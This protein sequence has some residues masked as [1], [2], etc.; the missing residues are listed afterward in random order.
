LI[1]VD[2]YCHLGECRVYDQNVFESEIVS[3]LNQNQVSA[4]IVA[5]FPGAPNPAS[6]HDRIADLGTRHPGRVFGLASVN[7]HI[8][9]DRY[10]AEVER[11]VKELGFVGVVLETLGHA[12]NPIGNDA[13]T[14]FEV[15]RQLHIPVVV[16]TG[17]SPYGLP[18]LV[19]PRAR[20]YSDVKIVL[21]NAGA[22]NYTQ[23]AQIVARE[24]SNVYLSTAWCR[25]D[26]IKTIVTDLGANR[27]MFAS[28]YPA[29]QTTELSKYRALTLFQFQQ[30]QAFSQTAM[31]VFGLQGVPDVPEVV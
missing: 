6:V 31:D 25:G 12:V 2:T 17:G 15:A 30:L 18:A 13:Q 3:T 20:S 19:L 28:D 5:P 1:I 4:V 8:N 14:V 10:R 11:C 23:E 24:A 21:A 7:P 27:V 16:H 9:R 22:V 29:N 26:D